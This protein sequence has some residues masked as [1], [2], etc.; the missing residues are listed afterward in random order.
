MSRQY[1]RQI[2]FWRAGW[3]KGRA[4]WLN[5]CR[6]NGN[7]LA[8][9]IVLSAIDSRDRYSTARWDRR[10]PESREIGDSI[11]SVERPKE[12]GGR[13]VLLFFHGATPCVCNYRQV[14]AKGSPLMPAPRDPRAHRIKGIRRIFAAI[15]PRLKERSAGDESA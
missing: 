4:I 1:F 10:G 15:D 5:V 7:S 3:C 9:K 2:I 8:P 12:T 13:A 11:A 6:P 14:P